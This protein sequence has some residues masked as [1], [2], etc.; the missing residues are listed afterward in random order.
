M[1]ISS[2]YYGRFWASFTC[3][4]EFRTTDSLSLLYSHKWENPRM[5]DSGLGLALCYVYLENR[6]RI[7]YC[8]R[9]C[10][11]HTDQWSS[12]FMSV[13]K[14]CQASLGWKVWWPLLKIC[15]WDLLNRFK[16]HC[17]LPWSHAYM[18]LM[19]TCQ[20]WSNLAFLPWPLTQKP[21]AIH[22]ILEKSASH[23]QIA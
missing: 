23:H 18:L 9:D 21:V 10:L 1:Y 13:C 22:C 5:Q 8:Q 2:R 19:S 16:T 15:H 7:Q 6:R 20:R 17:I 4:L 14:P 11:D 12:P 3:L